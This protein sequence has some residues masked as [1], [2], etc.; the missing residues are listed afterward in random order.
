MGFS[1]GAPDAQSYTRTYALANSNVS[2]GSCRTIRV[3]CKTSHFDTCVKA[4]C[5]QQQQTNNTTAPCGWTLCMQS[6]KQ[7][8]HE[9]RHFNEYADHTLII[10]NTQ[11]KGLGTTSDTKYEIVRNAVEMPRVSSL[12]LK[13]AAIC[14]EKAAAS[15]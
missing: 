6:R 8:S 1:G 7:S 10:T 2:V 12:P 14:S 9:Y 3:I 13:T 11:I 5:S 15:T 4:V